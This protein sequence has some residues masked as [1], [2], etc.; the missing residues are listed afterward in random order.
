MRGLV[1]RLRRRG[2]L[3]LLSCFFFGGCGGDGE[4]GELGG[5]LVGGFCINCC[6]CCCCFGFDEVVLLPLLF[7]E[8]VYCEIR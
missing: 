4:D 6:C 5:S 7:D 2:L 1:C 3:F 8:R